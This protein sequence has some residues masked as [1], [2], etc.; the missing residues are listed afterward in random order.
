MTINSDYASAL[1]S[2]NEA[3]QTYLAQKGKT[4]LT[5]AE[6]E[7][8]NQTVRACV[9]LLRSQLNRAVSD[10]KQA[11]AIR[12]IARDGLSELKMFDETF[13]HKR[14]VAEFAKINA[15]TQEPLSFAQML[16][17]PEKQKEQPTS[18]TAVTTAWG[19]GIGMVGGALKELHNPHLGQAV[20][21]LL[22]AKEKVR[23]ANEAVLRMQNGELP[24]NPRHLD[25][26]KRIQEGRKATLEHV[27]HARDVAFEKAGE[28]AVKRGLLFGVLGGGVGFVLGE[29]LAGDEAH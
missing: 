23:K 21:A 20:N 22:E 7:D 24:P 28:R 4:K 16:Q 2:V 18:I 14:K 3:E 12:D 1:K 9:H 5:P 8:Y 15:A 19:A 29:M 11:K 10:P 25:T 27:K 6:Q 17:P 26:A 13:W